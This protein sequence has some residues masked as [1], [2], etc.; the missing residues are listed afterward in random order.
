[1]LTAISGD[2][3]N[4]DRALPHVGLRLG[5]KIA[6]LHRISFAL[7][8]NIWSALGRSNRGEMSSKGATRSITCAPTGTAFQPDVANPWV[9]G[10]PVG[11]ASMTKKKWGGL[12]AG[13]MAVKLVKTLVLE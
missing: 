4:I 13:N 2:A 12:S 9:S 1:D 5:Q 10:N 7:T 6:Q 3:G 11:T 8:S